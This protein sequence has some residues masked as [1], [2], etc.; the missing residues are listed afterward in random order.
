MTRAAI[1]AAFP[2]E[3]K[4]LVKHWAHQRRA[5]VDLW[6]WRFDEGEWVAACAGAGQ[7]AA[8]RAFA[9][10]EHSGPID[11]A[12]SVGWAGALREEYVGGK[13]YYATGI[14]DVQT[15]ERFIAGWL[16]QEVPGHDFSRAEKAQQNEG[17]LAP[18]EIIQAA[19]TNQEKYPSGPKGQTHSELIDVRAKARTLHPEILLATSPRVAGHEE[20]LRLA[21][22]YSA[23]LVD[24][25]AAAV[26][27]L[28][29]MRGIPFYSIKGVS[30]GLNDRLPDFNRFLAPDGRLRLA[31]L[32][33]F[34]LFHPACW[35]ALVRMGEN[36][37]KAARAMAES[38]LDLL[39]ERGHIRMRNGYPD[40]KS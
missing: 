32:T 9:A 36:S 14:V 2:G 17:A 39:D 34:A 31:P 12:I 5:G 22:A 18:A 33:L 10:I 16:A 38:I 40:L 3:L 25:E 21:S 1:V 29:Q 19:D 28:A 7:A 23:A 26:A 11:F 13:A 6:R 4:P 35:P 27:R 20:K 15:G 8:T 30:D 37:K 24:M